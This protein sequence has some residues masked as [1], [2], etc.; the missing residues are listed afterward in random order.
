MRKPFICGTVFAVD[1]D[2][3]SKL[4]R[5]LKLAEENNE[6]IKKVYRYQKTAQAFKALYWIVIILFMV[7]GFFALKPYLSTLAGIYGP[8]SSTQPMTQA[9]LQ[10]LIQEIK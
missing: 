3:K 10:D 7:G 4:D 6:Y 1:A 5:A 9:Q 2:D 8:N